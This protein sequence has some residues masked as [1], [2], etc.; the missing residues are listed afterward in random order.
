MFRKGATSPFSAVRYL[1]ID[2]LNVSLRQHTCIE[3]HLG[4]RPR[5]LLRITLSPPMR[6]TPAVVAPVEADVSIA[7]VIFANVVA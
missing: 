7:A 3:A 5:P 6:H 4:V 2:S 1:P